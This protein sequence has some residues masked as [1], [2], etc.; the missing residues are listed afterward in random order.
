MLLVVD[1]VFDYYAEINSSLQ[2][3]WVQDVADLLNFDAISSKLGDAVGF[4]HTLCGLFA[5]FYICVIVWKSWAN[6]SQIDLYKCL[7]P[8]VIGLCIM[9][10]STIVAG[11]DLIAKGMGSVTQEFVD[12]CSAESKEQYNQ[13]AQNFINFRTDVYKDAA[14][15]TYD[16]L[17]GVKS[18]DHLAKQKEDL[19]Q[20]QAISA[21]ETRSWREKLLD[22]LTFIF[23]LPERIYLTIEGGIGALISALATLIAS[24]ISCC[25]LCMGFIGRCIFY[26]F[27]PVL[28]AMELIPGMEG[29]I[30]GWFKKYFT[31]CLY[32][33]IIQIVNGVLILL[34]VVLAK[35]FSGNP[36]AVVGAIDFHIIV[37][38]IGAFMF[39]NVPSVA[40]QI[41]DTASNGLGAA[42]L[43][44]VTYAAGKTGNAIAT[45]I[46]SGA[47][48][49][50]ISGGLSLVASGAKSMIK[51]GKDMMSSRRGAS[52]S[53]YKG[54]DK[55]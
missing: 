28:F 42:G 33:C 19:E 18:N 45:K 41:M 34:M 48:G 7:K 27:G 26:V 31:Y 3:N 37:G 38:V 39:M 47:A 44:P 46:G 9:N 40:S 29:R 43:V 11:V 10:F 30:A 17:S 24:I 20:E 53:N 1:S 25:I 12:K 35:G 52:N 32:P 8:F 49:S 2:Y 55:E 4:A 23:Q 6:G 16:Q 36:G 54:G 15:K 22:A 13:Y 5:L 21:T 14:K 51:K 50:A